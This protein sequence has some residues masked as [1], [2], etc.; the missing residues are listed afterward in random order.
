VAAARAKAKA[1]EELEEGEEEEEEELSEESEESW[2]EAEEPMVRDE[3]YVTLATNDAY[4]VGAMV[5]AYSIRATC[6]TRQLVAMVTPDVSPSVREVMTVFFDVI[7]D[8]MPLDSN[9]FD[10]LSLLNR[11]VVVVV[12]LYA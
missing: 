6:T 11:Q 9:D 10:N 1:G 2:D 4:A 5:L 8:V 7:F 12:L 3:A